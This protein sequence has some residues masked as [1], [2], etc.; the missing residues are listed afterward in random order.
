MSGRTAGIIGVLILIAITLA[1][2]SSTDFGDF[3]KVDTPVEIQQQMGYPKKMSLN[4]A[5]D[6]YPAWFE[7]VQRNGTQ[8]RGDI[9][10]ADELAGLFS[11]LT[12]QQ[13]NALGPEIMGLPIAGPMSPLITGLLG[14][15]GSSLRTR[16]EKE[17]SF[18]KGLQVGAETATKPIAR[19]SSLQ[20]QIQG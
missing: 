8:W 14:Y 4:Q 12:L 1:A 15:F 20:T 6:L 3:V 19:G 7:D 2:C 9:E 5:K 16:R 18:N 13:L 17:K 11:Q 10:R